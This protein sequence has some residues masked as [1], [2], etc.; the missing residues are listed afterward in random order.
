MA[1][2][3]GPLSLS[4]SRDEGMATIR[5]R[6]DGQTAGRAGR[7]RERSAQSGVESCLGGPGG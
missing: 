7:L 4:K 1:D 2:E 3:P 6:R 5:R